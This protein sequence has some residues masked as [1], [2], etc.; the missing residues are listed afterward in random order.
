MNKIPNSMPY[1]KGKELEYVTE[2]LN[3]G[4][5]SSQ[6]A[7]VTKFEEEFARWNGS[8]F[9][10]SVSNGTVALHL[11]L[12]ALG[13][14]EGDE[15]IVP[16]LTFIATA[17]VVVYT[18]ATPI[19]ADVDINTWNIDPKSVEEKITNRTKAIIPVHL[20]GN[21]ANMSEIMALS[22]KYGL[23][24]IEDAAEAHGSTFKG[25]KVGSIGHIGC[26]SFFGN[27]I[28]STGE[29]GMVVT[30]D[31][32][33][34]EKLNLLKNHGMPKNRKYWHPVIGF[35]YRMTNLQAAVGCAQLENADTFIK[36]R[37]R[38]EDKY[39]DLLSQE[40]NIV[41]QKTYPEAAKVNWLYSILVNTDSELVRN[42]LL[43]YLDSN[44]IEVRPT[45]NLINNMPC[46]SDYSS[47]ILKNSAKISQTG[48]S[49][50]VFYEITNEQIEYI[51][52][53]VKEFF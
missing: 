28:I 20:Y 48:L 35:N 8:K 30:D 33:I 52:N 39:N 11:A 32:E 49:L 25:K 15:V 36:Q 43:S 22:E 51:C 19:F 31:P 46:Y 9:A 3:S 38:I 4:W 13:I 37:K 1:L 12:E 53:R 7:F 14:G 24:V 2:A 40:K 34:F 44:E 45:F 41:L 23:Y 18:G 21:P 47:Q 50:P 5:I 16:A 6:G 26:F 29:G 27:K 17:N 42:D 10:S